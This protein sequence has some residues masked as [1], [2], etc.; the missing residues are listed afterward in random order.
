MIVL[1]WRVPMMASLLIWCA[2]WE[3]VGR[4]G[5]IFVLPPFSD[6]LA[7][8]PELIMLP[9]WQSATLTTLRTFAAGMALAVAVGIPI[10]LLMGR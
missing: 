5:A 1:G 2:L 8:I 3:A 4:T 6:V 10:G 7:R 9:S